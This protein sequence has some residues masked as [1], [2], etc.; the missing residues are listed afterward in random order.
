M[1]R[2]GSEFSGASSSFTPQRDVGVDSCRAPRRD[3]TGRN[4]NGEQHRRDDVQAISRTMM[5]MP[6]ISVATFA[7]LVLLG[8]RSLRIDSAEPCGLA[9]AAGVWRGAR[10]ELDS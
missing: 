9:S 5:A 7:R 3:E 2:I 4:G 1:A 8:P 10:Q 6:A